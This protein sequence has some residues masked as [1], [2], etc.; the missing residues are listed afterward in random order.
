MY[1]QIGYIGY[2][3]TYTYEY[4]IVR[5]G[6]LVHPLDMIRKPLRSTRVRE[7][8]R[9]NLTSKI[10]RAGDTYIG[11]ATMGPA[12]YFGAVRSVLNAAFAL[13]AGQQRACPYQNEKSMSLSH[14][15]RPRP[16]LVNDYARQLVNTD[17]LSQLSM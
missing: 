10:M 6:T 8:R 5:V 4:N 11:P 14:W 15:K 2:L 1:V 12:R 3:Q 7:M 13:L 17:H 9:D 16:A